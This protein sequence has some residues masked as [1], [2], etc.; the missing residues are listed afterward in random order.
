MNDV[1]AIVN[2]VFAAQE[3]PGAQE[4]HE[5]FEAPN[6]WL[7]ETSEI[8]WGTAAFV[9][10]LA[11]LIKFAGPAIKKS[12]Q[13]RT[14][15]IAKDIADAQAAKAAAER[16]AAEIRAA[17]GDINAER[18]RIL[19]EATEAAERVR[20]EGRAR[21]DA[22]IAELEIRAGVEIAGAGGRVVAELQSQVASLAL[23]ATERVIA[24][25]LDDAT[26]VELVERFIATVGATSGGGR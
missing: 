11:G 12:L 5:E 19:A 3:D 21:I 26:Q 14:D 23:T 20:V 22:E 6:T 13:G 9:I 17:K 10:I 8:I 2:A 4:E 24:A 15:R 7:P 16:R 25:E 1:T 18:E